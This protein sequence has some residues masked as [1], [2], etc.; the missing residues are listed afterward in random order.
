MVARYV[1]VALRE[2]D[3]RLLLRDVWWTSGTLAGVCTTR[4]RQP[5]LSLPLELSP[6]GRGSM[7]GLSLNKFVGSYL[8]FIC[9]RRS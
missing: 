8:A 6:H 5:A 7:F 2:S 3:H 4:P 9:A 1:T